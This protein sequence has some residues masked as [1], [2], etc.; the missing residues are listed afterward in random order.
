MR[1]LLIGAVLAMHAVP[2]G[3]QG[4]AEDYGRAHA[5]FLGGTSDPLEFI[6]RYR[7]A[8]TSGL[9]GAWTDVSHL[10]P[11]GN[12]EEAAFATACERLPV[13]IETSDRYTFHMIRM[14]GTDTEVDYAYT[15][16][17]G[18]TFSESVRPSQ[19]LARLHVTDE[20]AAT[21]TLVTRIG[22]MVTFH[23]PAPD[24]LVYTRL[25]EMPVIYARCP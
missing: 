8:V 19:Y 22:G 3:A 11:E 10:Y 7:A 6:N 9:D 23:R 13:T 16:M 17:G 5:V 2:A 24:I 1:S 20:Q 18:A 25:A 14:K 15:T 12:F 4:L 21:M